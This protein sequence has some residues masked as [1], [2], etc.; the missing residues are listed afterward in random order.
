MPHFEVLFYERENG[1]QPA[2]SFLI[3]LDTKMRARLLGL[4]SLLQE[5]GPALREPYTK[6]LRDGIFELRAKL[7]NDITRVLF[8]FV[9][10]RH[11]I[12]TNGFVKKD[13]R[14]PPGEIERARHYREDYLKR[15]G[16]SV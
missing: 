11:I 4:I 7:G 1:E 5:N 6:H 10:G 13:P 3:G 12:L 14:T 15:K 9:A 2:K 16:G 8:F